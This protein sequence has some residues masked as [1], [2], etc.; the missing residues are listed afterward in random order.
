MNPR[1]VYVYF[2]EGK[3]GHKIVLRHETPDELLLLVYR[4]ND[5]IHWCP[6]IEVPENIM[7]KV[8]DWYLIK[9]MS[10][11]DFIPTRGA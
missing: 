9:Q 5:T 8:Q 7:G 1:R 6:A 10:V 11:A 3:K 4:I 2:V